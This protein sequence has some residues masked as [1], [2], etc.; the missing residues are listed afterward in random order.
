MRYEI[1]PDT[2]LSRRL[3]AHLV[4]SPEGD[5]ERVFH[6]IRECVEWI[7]EIEGAELW[8]RLSSSHCV[9]LVNPSSP[10]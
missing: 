7:E 2:P 6:T 1:R 8:L 5:V 10:I 9:R 3:R 4:V